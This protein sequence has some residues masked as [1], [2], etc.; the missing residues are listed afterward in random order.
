[1]ADKIE[2]LVVVLS[3]STHSHLWPTIL[4]RNIP[5]LLIL[6]GGSEETIL[7]NRIVYLK[8]IDTYDGLSEK[9]MCAFDFILSQDNFN[10]ITHILKVDDHDTVFTQ[11]QIEMIPIKYKDIL[12]TQDYIGQ[13]LVPVHLVRR[14][15]HF[16]KV[17]LESKWYNKE[18]ME[19]IVP[20]LGGG[21]TYILSRKSLICLY[22]N[23]DV[24][25][26]YASYEDIMVGYILYKNNILPYKLDYGIKCQ[27]L[28]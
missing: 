23:K 24:Y 17:P 14:Y 19:E 21:D 10:S 1:M 27:L 18:F 2:L 4:N 11:E 7:D 5:N 26:K 28:G 9:M 20:F 25:Y 12:T 3:C 15:H 8:C 22:N 6:C 13:S 16:G